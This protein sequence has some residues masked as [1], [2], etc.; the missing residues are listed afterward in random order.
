LQQWTNFCTN[1]SPKKWGSG[2]RVPPVEKVEDAVPR[3][4]APQHP[5]YGPVSVC[6]CLCLSVTS[7]CSIETAE[8]IGLFLAWELP[9]TYPTLCCKE[10]QASTEMRVL[11][12]GTFPKLRSP[13]LSK[14]RHG[15]SIVVRAINLGR[16]RC[17]R[18]ERDKLD[19][20]RP[21]KLIAPPSSDARPL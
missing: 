1:F 12:C 21:A 16:K 14:F 10:I 19:R 3:V 13:D 4:P 6:V 11:S 8:R 7:R 9:S 18:S 5:C 17:R 15:M 20:R 2:G